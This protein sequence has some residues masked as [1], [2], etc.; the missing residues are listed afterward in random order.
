MQIHSTH[1]LDPFRNNKQE[2]SGRYI[3]LKKCGM[4]GLF[5][6]TC[7]RPSMDACLTC[8]GPVFVDAACS[9]SDW[10]TDPSLPEKLNISQLFDTGHR[11]N[12]TH[13][14]TMHLKSVPCKVK[15]I[16]RRT[17]VVWPRRQWTY[18]PAVGAA[19]PHCPHTHGAGCIAEHKVVLRGHSLKKW[20]L[21]CSRL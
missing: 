21:K 3:F 17:E 13:G 18:F 4:I 2:K 11:A 15:E 1:L 20:Q 14:L 7:L 19:L 9:Q 5:I 8:R 12:R 16:R 10:P 6:F